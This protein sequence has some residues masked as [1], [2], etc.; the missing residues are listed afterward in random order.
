MAHEENQLRSHI[1]QRS[2]GGANKT[3]VYREEHTFIQSQFHDG[4]DKD[5]GTDTGKVNISSR[6]DIQT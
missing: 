6:D 1:F 3:Y 5:M 4:N 2:T